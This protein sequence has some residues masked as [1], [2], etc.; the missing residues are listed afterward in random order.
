MDLVSQT[1]FKSGMKLKIALV[2]MQCDSPEESS[3]S[4]AKLLEITRNHLKVL[5]SKVF[6]VNEEF[7]TS[8]KKVTKDILETLHKK[9]ALL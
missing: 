6:L 2:A 5:S 9:V 3:E 8:A 4:H 1:S 7:T